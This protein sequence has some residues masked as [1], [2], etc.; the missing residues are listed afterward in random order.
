MRGCRVCGPIVSLSVV[1]IICGTL[2][3]IISISWFVVTVI[4]RILIS[5]EIGVKIFPFVGRNATI[6]VT[7][8]LTSFVAALWSSIAVLIVA[9]G[10]VTIVIAVRRVTLVV[11]LLV[12]SWWFAHYSSVNVRLFL[13]KQRVIFSPQF[14]QWLW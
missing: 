13:N 12:E 8:I 6:L 14:L 1:P 5:F 7:I 2:V 4:I 11:F 3:V 10:I 9:A